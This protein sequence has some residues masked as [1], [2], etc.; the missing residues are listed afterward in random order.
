MA[1]DTPTTVLVVTTSGTLAF[2]ATKDGSSNYTMQ[3]TPRVNGAQVDSTNPMAINGTVELGAG[4]LTIGA[5]SL[6]QSTNV[7][8]IGGLALALGQVIKA[9]SVPVTM[10]SDQGALGTVA[11]SGTIPVT[12]SIALTGTS[13]VSGTVAVS[14]TIPVSGTVAL[15]GTQAVQGVA[16]SGTTVAGSPVLMGARAATASPTAVTDGQAVDI[17]TDKIGRIINAGYAIPE[18]QLNGFA[19]STGTT[20]TTLIASPGS[21]ISIF[22]TDLEVSNSSSIASILTL[23]DPA[24]IQ[25]LVPAGGGREIH[26]QTPVKLAAN[27][28]LTFT[29]GTAVSS[30]LVGA[31]GFKG[32]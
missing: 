13:P 20:A 18:N 5:L 6:H 22:L 21:A 8:Q 17:M 26:L 31:Q 24:S 3:T 30:I 29:S 28:P 27:T 14:G 1:D 16:G 15:S 25:L 2:T 11:V 32:A 10:A 4:T 7:D 9:S 23:N 12:G 19:S